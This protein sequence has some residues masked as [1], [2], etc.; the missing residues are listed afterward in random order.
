LEKIEMKTIFLDTNVVLDFILKRKGFA[1]E[2][3]RIFDLGERK[4][5]RLSLSSLSMNNIDY[6]VSK[7]ES[8]KKSRQIVLKL[9]S[10]V[11]V[12]KVDRSTIEKAALS[13]FI[14]F[15]DAIQNYCAEE[16]GVN[17]IIT[18]NLKDFRK[19]ELSIQTPKEFLVSFDLIDS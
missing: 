18:R 5:L 4:K 15:E 10:L 17:N 19:S 11:D 8:K 6:I 16:G 9:L 1:E 13:N 14:D 3:A 12:F 7:I 2:A